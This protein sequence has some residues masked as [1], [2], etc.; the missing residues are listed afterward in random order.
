[1]V[2]KWD[3]DEARLLKYMR[4][5]PKRK[6][7]WLREINEFNEHSLPKVSK[8]IRQELRNWG[9]DTA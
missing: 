4:I 6:L 8:M 9:C 7:E 3:S 5:S 2:Y 1:M